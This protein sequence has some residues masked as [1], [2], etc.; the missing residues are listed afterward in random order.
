M[1]PKESG[2]VSLGRRVDFDA[3]LICEQNC[4]DAIRTD[5]S[6]ITNLE[7]GRFVMR[8]LDRGKETPD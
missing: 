7:S 2:E 4:L 8:S 6:I 5:S 1:E 3:T